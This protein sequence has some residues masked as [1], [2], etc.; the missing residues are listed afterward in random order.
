MTIE[1]SE[2]VNLD[3]DLAVITFYTIL[4]SIE[5]KVDKNNIY[6]KNESEDNMELRQNCSVKS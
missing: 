3:N 5:S 1:Y 6:D 2:Y 4:E